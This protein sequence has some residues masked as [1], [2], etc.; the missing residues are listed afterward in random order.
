[1]WPEQ[2]LASLPA[3]LDVLTDPADCGPV[4]LALPQDVQTVAYDYPRV[5]LRSRASTACAAPAPIRR[6]GGLPWRCA[7]A[8]GPL[9]VAGG[10]VHYAPRL[11]R[12]RPTSPSAMACRSPRPRPARA[13]CPGTIRRNVGAIGVT[14]SSAANAAGGARPTWCWPS[15][16]AWRTSPPARGRCSRRPARARS[17]STSRP[18]TPPSMARCRSWRTRRGSRELSA[19]SAAG[20]RRRPGRGARAGWRGWKRAGGCASRR[21]SDRRAADRCP[22]AGCGQPRGLPTRRRGLRGRRPAGRAAQA[23]ARR[24]SRAATTSNTASRAWATRSPA[25][26]A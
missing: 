7:G 9:I 1:M 19:A 14:G 16:R 23:L 15:A 5:L 22:G 25:A 3:A 20:T 26:S 11:R 24:A 2:L 10:G 17:A 12:A 21:P 13:R 18:S 4:T 6:A 8:K